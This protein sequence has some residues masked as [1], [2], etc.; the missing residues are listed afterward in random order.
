MDCAS[1]CAI[2]FILSS[3]GGCA[4]ALTLKHGSSRLMR[5]KQQP[6]PAATVHQKSEQARCTFLSGKR[7]FSLLAETVRKWQVEFPVTTPPD[8]TRCGVTAQ[9]CCDDT[10]ESH[11]NSGFFL[12]ENFISVIHTSF[13]LKYEDFCVC[14][15][16]CWSE[17][18]SAE[19]CLWRLRPRY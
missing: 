5:L 11:A 17:Y 13:R 12:R 15:H 3:W 19:T 6:N 4:V 8:M 9:R 10:A 7:F 16:K 18:H 14:K 2:L 1:S